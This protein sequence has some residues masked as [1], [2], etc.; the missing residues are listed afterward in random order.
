M[1]IDWHGIIGHRD[2]GALGRDG[3]SASVRLASGVLLQGG[4]D[5][6]YKGASSPI[7]YVKKKDSIIFNPY[8]LLA[9]ICQ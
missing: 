5:R 1:T 8:L 9:F 4:Y 7:R 6:V 3:L 2:N